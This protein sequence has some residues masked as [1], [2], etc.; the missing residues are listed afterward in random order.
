VTPWAPT[1]VFLARDAVDGRKG[2]D[3]LCQVVRDVFGDDPF[4]SAAY[5][6]FN[7][8]RNRLRALVWE[9]NGFWLHLKRIEHGTFGVLDVEGRGTSLR[10]A[11]DATELA[12]LLAGIERKSARIRKHFARELGIPA[13]TRDERAQRPAD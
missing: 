9:Q 8:R 11:L 3:G 6:F 13:R 12:L 7:R 2:I 4:S 10:V 1:R 5:L